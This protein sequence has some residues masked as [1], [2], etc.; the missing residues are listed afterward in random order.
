M[1]R[2]IGYKLHGFGKLPL[3]HGRRLRERIDVFA[4]PIVMFKESTHDHGRGMPPNRIPDKNAVVFFKVYEVIRLLGN[5]RPGVL[6]GFFLRSAVSHIVI[7]PLVRFFRNDL[8][9]IPA[10]LLGNVFCH[11]LGIL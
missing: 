2:A 9:K 6:F 8:H 5:G 7:A 4:R 10:C 3:I 11:A 1:I